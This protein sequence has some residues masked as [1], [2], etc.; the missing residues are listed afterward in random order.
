MTHYKPAGEELTVQV[1][2]QNLDS[3]EHKTWVSVYLDKQG[4]KQAWVE[5]PGRVVKTGIDVVTGAGGMSTAIVKLDTTVE[6]GNYDLSAA[7]AVYQIDGTAL[8]S[9]RVYY[10]KPITV[11]LPK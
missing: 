7:V 2:L 6:A 10:V 4:G 3:V 5:D 1:T 8:A 11:A 9:D